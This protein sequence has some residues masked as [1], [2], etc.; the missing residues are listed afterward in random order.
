[1]MRGSRK[2]TVSHT[3][4]SPIR[5]RRSPAPIP[6]IAYRNDYVAPANALVPASRRKRGPTYPRPSSL[7][8]GSRLSPGGWHLI[9]MRTLSALF[10][11]E[12]RFLWQPTRPDRRTTREAE[13]RLAR[14]MCAQG[15]PGGR[16]QMHGGL[17]ALIADRDDSRG[18]RKAFRPR[19]RE[20]DLLWAHGQRR[21]RTRRQVHGLGQGDR[22]IGPGNR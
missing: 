4:G 17:P 7:K 14:Q 22:M 12:H 20:A 21:C 11:Q 3:N 1:M 5:N 13:R 19:W 8:D 10:G 6:V 9:G 18:E 15:T 16:R 2:K